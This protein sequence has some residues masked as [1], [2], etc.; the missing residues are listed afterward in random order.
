MPTRS[1]SAISEMTAPPAAASPAAA[2]SVYRIL[3]TALCCSTALRNDTR[4][5]DLIPH[6][7]PHGYFHPLLPMTCPQ[8]LAALPLHLLLSCDGAGTGRLLLHF[9]FLADR[10]RPVKPWLPLHRGRARRL[11][12]GGLLLP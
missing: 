11:S 3:T 4:A 6:L 8:A 5:V 7:L 12:G 1:S 2:S 9:L 10:Q